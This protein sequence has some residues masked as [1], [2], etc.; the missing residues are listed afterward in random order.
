VKPFSRK[1]EP[2]WKMITTMRIWVV[3]KASR[4]KVVLS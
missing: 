3:T 4:H 1:T 2:T